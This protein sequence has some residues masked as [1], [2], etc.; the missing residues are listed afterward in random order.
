MAVGTVILP[1][2]AATPPDGS[3]GNAGPAIKRVQGTEANPKKHVLVADFDAATDEFLYWSFFLPADAAADPTF[4]LK[5]LWSS[6]AAVTSTNV[7]WAASIG[8]ITPADADTPIEH[9]LPGNQTVTDAN[10]T[11]EAGRLNTASIAFTNV[12]ADNA[13]AGDLIIV[14]FQR[15]ADNGSDTLVEDARLWGLVLEYLLA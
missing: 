2:A 10:D 5:A 6:I 13:D 4:T 14:R 12:Q 11:V 8:A 15:D 1:I 7:V 9:A 3:A